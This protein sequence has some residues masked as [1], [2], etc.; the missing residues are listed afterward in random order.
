M[1]DIAK[2]PVSVKEYLLVLLVL[3][4]C[5]TG[6]LL[7][8]VDQCPDEAGRRFLSN[9]IV[10]H[11]ELPTGD[12]LGTMIMS[13]EDASAEAPR[14]VPGAEYQGW[15]FSYALRPFLSSMVGAL[16]QMLTACFTDSPRM[17]LAA[18]RMCSV[19]PVTLCCFFCLRMGH[20]LFERRSSAVLLPV[21]VCF[22]P[23]VMFLGM[24]QNNDSLSLCAVSMMLY[25][26]VEGYDS[27]W[28]V[29]SCIGLA[30]SFSLGLLSYYSIYGWILMG[31]VF[32]IL[33]VSTD[34]AIHGKGR[35]IL[36]R[37]LLIFGICLFL[38]GWFFV[39]NAWLHNGD[40]LGIDSEAVSRSRM[41]AL[42]YRLFNYVRYRDEGVSIPAF[43][44]MNRFWWLRMTLMSFVG[45]FGYMNIM[46][47]SVLYF[48][49]ALVIA[50]GM[51]LFAVS[52]SRQRLARRD[53]LMM[54][55]LLS[56]SVITFLLH[57]W[58]SYARDL[59]PQ[60][61]Y[62]ITLVLPLGY[63]LAYGLDKFPKR[64]NARLYLA[65]VLT[66]VWLALFV[67]AALGTMTKMLPWL[68]INM[69]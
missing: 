26:L 19:L 47:P 60:G 32:C 17:L 42:G 21:L 10:E 3:C 37:G 57:F 59:Q 39:R 8:P 6:A 28:T 5:L 18:S 41:E 25:Y 49:Y 24:Y 44:L 38:A 66:C 67:W 20:R 16:F 4:I 48:L 13:W 36:K 11:R 62:I 1:K 53:R 45:V 64:I 69:A 15:G 61:R 58:Q 46:L 51:V 33:A 31:A 56:T 55:L 27:K 7:L 14:I 2:K 29:K 30:V 22:L 65:P 12:E 43:L 34:P 52:L 23:Q 50:G 9:W 63:M 35:L 40:F 68:Q 54:L